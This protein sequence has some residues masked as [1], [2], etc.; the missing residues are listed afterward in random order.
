ML[1]SL[2]SVNFLAV[3]S[4]FREAY[5]LIACISGNLLKERP[6][7]YTI[8]KENGMLA[9]FIAFYKMMVVSGW[10]CHE[11]MIVMDNTAIHTGGN[12]ADIER[13]F[14]ETVVGG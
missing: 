13:F 1:P 5:N 9:T 4:N 7:V 8:G 12:S 2:W 11:K 6:L 14:W 3:S 10:L